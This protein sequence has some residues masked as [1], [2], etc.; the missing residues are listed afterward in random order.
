MELSEIRNLIQTDLDQTTALIHENLRSPV[1]ILEEIGNYIIES[2]GKRSRAVLALLAS[3]ACNLPLPQASLFAAII[4][5]IHAA[6]LLHDDVV[7]VSEL[8]RGKPSANVI[9]GNAASVLSGD[10]LYSRTFEM[11]VT[12]NSIPTL[13]ALANA[14]NQLAEGEMLQL[15]NCHKTD[16]SENDY[17]RVIE[18]KTATLFAVSGKIPALLNGASKE[19]QDALSEFGRLVGIA[20]QL[21]DDIIDYTSNKAIMG[22]NQGD[23]LAEGKM[24][25][26]LIYA[27]ALGTEAERTLIDEAIQHGDASKLSDIIEI[28]KRTQSPQKILEKAQYFVCEAKNQLTLLPQNEYTRALAHYADL[29][30]ARIA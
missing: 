17:L 1:P 27:K 21:I 12:L 5:M 30:I 13:K 26:P 20:F 4:E 25:L 2:G 19:I 6:T 11:M 8:R 29:A 14:S 16:L 18:R 7:D 9:Y 28:I 15:Q 22:K 23:D 10:F 3:R 24:T